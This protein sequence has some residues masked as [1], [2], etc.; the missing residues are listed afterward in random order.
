[1]K[2]I[3]LW[4]ALLISACVIPMGVNA[5]S[6]SI[7]VT[8]PSTAVQGNKVTVTVKLSATK[9]KL[10]SWQM[11]LNYDKSY[12][13]LVSASSEGGGSTMVNYTS[14]G[15]KSK[16]YTFTFEARKTGTTKVSVSSY[17][18]YDFDTMSEMSLT[19]SSKTIRIMTQSELEA[20][21][22]S[23][24]TLSSLGVTGHELNP[25]FDKSTLEY[26]V[27]VENDVTTATITGKKADSNASVSGLN[28]VEL[29][30]GNNRF[31]VTVTA[32]K[33]NTQTYVV[34]I[35]R[36]EKNPINV[37]YAGKNYS[38]IRKSNELGELSTFEGKE[39]TY[40]GEEI[41]ALYNEVTDT[42]LIGLK[43]EDG[44]VNLAIL[45]E[46]VIAL[47]NEIKSNNVVLYPQKLPESSSFDKYI[48][49]NIKYD[50]MT[51]EGYALNKKSN[52]VIIYAEN[53]ET[54]DL[55]YYQYD[56]EN[57][58]IQLYSDEL[59]K[60]YEELIMKYKYV[61]FGLMG[62]SFL[63]FL[64]LILR[65]PKRV[66]KVEEPTNINNNVIKEIK[67]E[68]KKSDDLKKKENI[69][70][71]DLSETELIEQIKDIKVVKNESQEEKKVSK[72]EKKKR[73]KLT[74]DFDI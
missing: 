6:G 24:A 67:V 20:T 36:K 12:L 5:A 49:K 18:A 2:R 43:D 3:K 64:I 63:L 26:N 70:D 38:V 58:T 30:E 54:G 55:A 28:T 9:G 8:G 41:P 34:N 52:I 19:S 50:D 40:Q 46:S 17:E 39:I 61:I 31:E 53:M 73:Q 74:K 7:S 42:T 66:I 72:K 16:S 56:T 15:T 29:N 25:K 33:G 57:Q 37:A 62:L 14:S 69:N 1:M 10:G 21:Y 44:K 27:E 68:K 23:N 47:Y 11:D 51:V 13:K 35:Y 32:Q 22:S 4:L 48:R 59:D 65:K 60:Y 71:E 45:E